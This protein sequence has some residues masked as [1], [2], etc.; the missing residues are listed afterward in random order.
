RLHA[1]LA[2]LGAVVAVSLLAL[3]GP[4]G[5]ALLP[6]NPLGFTW[7][8]APT[9]VSAVILAW[10]AGLLRRP[11]SKGAPGGWDTDEGRETDK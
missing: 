11:D 5:S 1:G 3:P 8:L 10:P 6:A 2:A 9:L 7:T 4:S